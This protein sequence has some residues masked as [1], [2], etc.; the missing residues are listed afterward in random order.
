MIKRANSLN[1]GVKRLSN[2]LKERR[3]IEETMVWFGKYPS[4][5][6]E[7][8]LIE[9][10]EREIRYHCIEQ[11]DSS[12]RP[13]LRKKVSL[14]WVNIVHWD[15]YQREN[16][17]KKITG[18]A[19]N[20]FF[21]AI[22]LRRLNDWVPQV[23]EVAISQIIRIS[24]ETQ[25]AIIAMGLYNILPHWRSWSRINVVQRQVIIDLISLPE[26]IAE[27]R[28]HIVSNYS[29]VRM[30][31]FM[32]LARLPIFDQYLLD[33]TH[34]ALQPSV[35]AKAYRSLF[36]QRVSWF[37]G[38]ERVWISRCDGISRMKPIIKHRSI[39]VPIVFERLLNEASIDPSSHVRCLAAEILIKELSTLGDQARKYA[40]IFSK[41]HSKAVSERGDFALR[42]LVKD[43][44]E[45]H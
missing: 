28:N 27:I 6:I 24:Q 4:N 5:Y 34:K 33:I 43:N 21:F 7:F 26:V 41:D 11:I 31:T 8:S 10:W 45:Q 13:L 32:E 44:S 42:K 3:K 39:N 12:P 36:E 29:A 23:R 1:L 35:R 16:A 19:P 9:Y 17:L 22:L 20:P 37:V 18:S 15:G 38:R 25:P 2:A 40:E 14:P 30:A